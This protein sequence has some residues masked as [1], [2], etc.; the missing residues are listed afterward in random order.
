MIKVFT[1][2]LPYHAIGRS[3]RLDFPI[4]GNERYVTGAFAVANVFLDEQTMPT[5]NQ[6]GYLDIP[7]VF[8]KVSISSDGKVVSPSVPLLSRILKH[9]T[10]YNDEY[11]QR[12]RL[13]STARKL[14]RAVD[15]GKLGNKLSIIIEEFPKTNPTEFQSDEFGVLSLT[16]TVKV[17]LKTIKKIC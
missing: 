7:N 3:Y 5:D 13:M 15:F 14:M 6:S 17:Y 16:Y 12:P 4:S 8:G 2:K 1:I 11:E 10:S 9:Y